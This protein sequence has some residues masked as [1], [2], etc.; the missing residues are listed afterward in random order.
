M[1]ILLIVVLV[2]YFLGVKERMT[3][4]LITPSHIP[5]DH[6]SIP[7]EKVDVLLLNLGIPDGTDFWSIRRY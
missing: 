4:D 7:K 6:P 2:Y 5:D 3:E 1:Q